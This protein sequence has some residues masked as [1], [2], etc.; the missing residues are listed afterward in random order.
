MTEDWIANKWGECYQCHR[1]CLIWEYG[2]GSEDSRCQDCI[3]GL[4]VSLPRRYPWTC[5]N[6]TTTTYQ[7]NP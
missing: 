2:D 4:A 3:D 6:G 7:V 1:G 5:A